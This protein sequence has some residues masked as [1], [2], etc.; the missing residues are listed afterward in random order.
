MPLFSQK[1]S[2]N[3]IP[4]YLQFMHLNIKNPILFH[5]NFK[6]KSKMKQILITET[7]AKSFFLYNEALYL[8]CF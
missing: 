5:D 3:K 7:L 8:F 1:P 6:I 2:F 4:V